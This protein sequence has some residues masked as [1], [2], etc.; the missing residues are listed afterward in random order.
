MPLN[1]IISIRE[2]QMGRG[3]FAKKEVVDKVGWRWVDNRNACLFM[4][5]HSIYISARKGFSKARIDSITLKAR[6]VSLDIY[7]EYI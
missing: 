7:Q 4:A 1:G 6:I 3:S 2:R 5:Q